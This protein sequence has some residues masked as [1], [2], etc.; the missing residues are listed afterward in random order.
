MKRILLM[1][2]LAGTLLSVMIMG[3]CGGG[4]SSDAVQVIHNSVTTGNAT[5]YDAGHDLVEFDLHP[6]STYT[7]NITNFA[8][9][10]RLVF[11]AGT[12]VGLTNVSG[13]YNVIDVIGSLNGNVV[14]VHLTGIPAATDAQI[15]G[16]NSFKTVFGADSLAP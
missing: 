6:T 5:T 3:G 9:G 8:A 4:G 2:G 10:D 16:V 14:T 7:Y 15:F 1:M 12:A 13:A 11:D